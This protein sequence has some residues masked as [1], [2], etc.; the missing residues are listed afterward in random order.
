ML[1]FDIAS[2]PPLPAKKHRAPDRMAEFEDTESRST[3]AE[4]VLLH[5]QQ[6]SQLQTISMRLASVTDLAKGPLFSHT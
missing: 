3:E 5:T 6:G 4:P 1:R 2:E